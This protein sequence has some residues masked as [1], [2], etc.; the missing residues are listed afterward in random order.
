MDTLGGTL[1]N[2]ISDRDRLSSLV[3][4]TITASEINT[5]GFF[6]SKAG[7]EYLRDTHTV[8]L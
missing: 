3:E 7:K 1:S 6:F 2:C 5:D 4:K 8:I